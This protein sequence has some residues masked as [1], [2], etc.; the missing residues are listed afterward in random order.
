MIVFVGTRRTLAE[1]RT[2][3]AGNG[4][5]ELVTFR[6]AGPGSAVRGGGPGGP[7]KR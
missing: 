4:C 2:G 3:W 1:R 6:V 5:W 7:A